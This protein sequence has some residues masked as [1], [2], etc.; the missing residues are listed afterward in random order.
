MANACGRLLG[1]L[2][3]GVLYQQAGVAA[4]LWGAVVLAGSAGIGAMFLPPVS[5]AAVSWTGAKGDD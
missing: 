3:S 2:L 5:S 1:T 4:S